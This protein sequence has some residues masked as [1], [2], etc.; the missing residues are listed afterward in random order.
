MNYNR[1]IETIESIIFL[2]L[3]TLTLWITLIIVN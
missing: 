3:L 2:T 1:I